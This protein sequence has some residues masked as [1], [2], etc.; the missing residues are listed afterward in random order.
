MIPEKNEMYLELRKKNKGSKQPF[1]E[2]HNIL[3]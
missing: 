1:Y 3:W 2:S